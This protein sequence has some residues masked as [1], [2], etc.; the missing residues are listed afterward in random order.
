MLIYSLLV[1]IAGMLL[2]GGISTLLLKRKINAQLNAIQDMLTQAVAKEQE[3]QTQNKTLQ[4]QLA[5]T[6]YLLKEC[7][8]ECQHLRQ[9]TSKP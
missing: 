4:Q 2:G 3:A 1:L 9:T 5:D 7:Q 8:K 6:Q